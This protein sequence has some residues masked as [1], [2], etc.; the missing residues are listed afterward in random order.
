MNF[1][2]SLCIL[3]TNP[4]IRYMCYSM[5]VLAL[6]QVSKDKSL[7][8]KSITKEFWSL[9]QLS[10]PFYVQDQGADHTHQQACCEN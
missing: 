3:D 2:S 8:P 1:K 7:G 6:S 10:G 9:G 4:F 5:A